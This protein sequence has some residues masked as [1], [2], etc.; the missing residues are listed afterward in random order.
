MSIELSRLEKAMDE[1]KAV[2]KDALLVGS[3]WDQT[4][5]LPL[6]GYN[7][8]PAAAALLSQLIAMLGRHL[9]TAGF[10]AL[11]RFVFLQFQHGRAGLAVL[12][13]CLQSRDC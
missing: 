7:S 13:R 1:A 6:V 5:G 4:N 12:R 2:L 8:S 3:I 11:D 10:P 9:A